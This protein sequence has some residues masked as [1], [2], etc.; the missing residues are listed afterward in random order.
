MPSGLQAMTKQDALEQVASYL[1]RVTI[2]R[3]LDV[4][5]DETAA[6]PPG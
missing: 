1:E 3:D 4:T 5:R 2:V 6:I